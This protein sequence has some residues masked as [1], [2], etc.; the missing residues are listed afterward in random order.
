MLAGV[1]TI[2][3]LQSPINILS[4]T[5]YPSTTQ[6]PIPVFGPS[7]HPTP[8]ISPSMS[9]KRGSPSKSLSHLSLPS[10]FQNGETR[11]IFL[12]REYECGLQGL[13]NGAVPGFSNIWGEDKGL[14][15]LRSVHPVS[16]QVVPSPKPGPR[17]NHRYSATTRRY[18][19]PMSS[20][21]PGRNH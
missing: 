20:R 1:Y 4:T 11:T 16:K 17:L 19:I 12:I 14:W 9:K 5:L 21:T 3:P 6:A 7:S 2:L 13:R 15:G 10:T 8:V 18:I